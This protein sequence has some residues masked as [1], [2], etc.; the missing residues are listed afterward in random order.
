MKLRV[1]MCQ[2]NPIV[3][4]IEGNA[5]K[6]LSFYN[7]ALA[8]LPDIISFPELALSGYPPEDLLLKKTFLKK[9]IDFLKKIAKEIHEG[10]AV[11]GLPTVDRN[12]KVY[13][14]AGII[15]RGK[16]KAFY[17]KVNIP[18]YGAFDEKRYFE[19]GENS[20]VFRTHDGILFGV[21]IGEDILTQKGVSYLQ[22]KM[23][24]RLLLNISA[25]HYHIGKGKERKRIIRERA[26][27]TGCHIFYNNLVGG[28][29]ELVFDGGS[30][31]VSK[32][33]REI[34]GGKMFEEDIIV[35]DVEVEPSKPGKGIIQLETN[36]KKEKPEIERR[37]LEK[38]S[39][40]EEIYRALVL[41]VRDYVRKNHFEKV[42]L[43]ISGGIDSALTAVIAV[44]ALGKENV[45]GISMPSHYSSEETKSDAKKLAEN[46]GIKFIEVPIKPIYDAYMNILRDKFEGRPQDTTE[47]NLQSRIRGTIL[48][49]FSN[50]FGYL[51]L[52]TGNKSE[53]SVGYCTLYGDMVGGFGVLKDVPKT[54][55]YELAKYRNSKEGRDL[56]PKSIIERPPTAELREGQ[57]DEDDIPPYSVLD[58]IIELYVVK[59][60][61]V[62]YI[63]KKT[64]LPEKLVREV[65]NRIDRNE[66]KRRQGPP[67]IK[68]TQ[69]AFGK[70]RRMP[71]VNRFMI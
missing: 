64:G 4:D 52:N 57:K 26:K 1:A 10:I 12:G 19:P 28:Q 39:G 49:A 47:E 70:D 67:G 61:D 46:L 21:N 3:G 71:I 66:Y 68:I 60:H 59:E 16:V 30:F 27:E 14:S 23:G 2:I 55:V 15:E 38:L 18:T 56:I 63:I 50:K 9:N 48:M 5:E 41:G 53:L 6:I 37:K 42:V 62:T 31:V 29:D 51:V 11:V 40:I 54:L 43:G 7:R 44:D 69:K 25:S 58:R 35:A 65:I 36:T 33:G 17:F 24:A 45:V 13:N 22:A 8:H 32:D 20:L 34:A